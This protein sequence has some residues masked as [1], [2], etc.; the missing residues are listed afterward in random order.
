MFGDRRESASIEILDRR[1][2]TEVRFHLRLPP[3]LPPA[4]VASQVFQLEDELRVLKQVLERP[5]AP[6]GSLA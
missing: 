6:A 1:P 2:S 5:A 4:K 3:A